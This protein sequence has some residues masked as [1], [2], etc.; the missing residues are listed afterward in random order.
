M[1]TPKMTY[2]LS[3]FNKFIFL[4]E[5]MVR[6]IANRDP[7]DEI[8]VVD[9]GSSDGTV[10]YLQALFDEGII[11]Q[12]IS[13]RDSGEA[14]GFNKGMLIAK[15]QLIKILSDDDAFYW[16]GIR[17]C[18]EFMLKNPNVD[19]IATDGAFGDWR[20][21]KPIIE[22]KHNADYLKYKLNK[23]PFAFCGLG[24]MLRK[25]SLSLLGLFDTNFMRVD[26]EYSLRVTS[27]KANLAWYS[28]PVW[29]RIVNPSSNSIRQTNR[30]I[31]EGEMLDQRYFRSIILHR[32]ILRHIKDVLRPI[33]HKIFSENTRFTANEQDWGDVF[34]QSDLWLEESS[35]GVDGKFLTR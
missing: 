6:L 4:R 33:K 8:I 5:V 18:R 7:E 34:Q 2:L 12:F 22:I 24:L 30:G 23:T 1:N 11:N 3:T 29:L 19:L 9:G 20:N 27:G 15:G 17:S 32:Q 25:S 28:R 31:I 26:A 21:A 35:S 10:E 14:H 16:P 13:E